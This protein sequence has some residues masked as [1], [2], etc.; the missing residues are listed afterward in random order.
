[1]CTRVHVESDLQLVHNQVSVLESIVRTEQLLAGWPWPAEEV[2]QDNIGPVP[3]LFRAFFLFHSSSFGSFLEK[4]LGTPP[5]KST[6][7]YQAI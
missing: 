4:T 7:L 1:M 2:D 3:R 6:K 5:K